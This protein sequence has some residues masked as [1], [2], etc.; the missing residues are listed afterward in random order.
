MRGTYLSHQQALCVYSVTQPCLTLCNSTDPPDS[1]IYEVRRNQ[2][3]LR[4][5]ILEVWGKAI[6][7]EA[8][9]LDLKPGSINY[10][11]CCLD[12]SPHLP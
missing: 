11:L 12:E 8:V 7:L 9:H 10:Y 5:L 2:P 1:S 3:L 4:L 6:S